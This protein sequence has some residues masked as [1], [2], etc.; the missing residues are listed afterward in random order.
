[1]AEVTNILDTL[2]VIITR[3]S[4]NLP[5]SL[6]L[7]M[8]ISRQVL[9]NHLRR[10]EATHKK[11]TAAKCKLEHNISVKI[12]S[13][14]IDA[15]ILMNREVNTALHTQR[16]PLLCCSWLKVSTLCVNKMS[17]PGVGM[18]LY[19]SL[20][21]CTCSGVPDEDARELAEGSGR[22]FEAEGSDQEARL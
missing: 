9:N 10:A 8:I 12:T 6:R 19:T 17:P 13:V 20:Y 16:K 11:L 18:L 2:Q 7:S 5:K 22:V 15:N 14:N 4:L 3:I 1:M 21:Y